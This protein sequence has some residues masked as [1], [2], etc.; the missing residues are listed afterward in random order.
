M[1]TFKSFDGVEIA[2]DDMGV[3][4][5]TLL[6]HGFA[7]D[8]RTN[9]VRPGVAGALVEA[10]RRVVLVDARGHGRSEKPHDVDAYRGGAMARDARALLDHLGIEDVA[11][12]GYSMGSFVAIRLAVSDDRVRALVLGGAGTAQIGM[13]RREH[14]DRIAD[15][16]E[17][18]DKTMIT[19][20]TALA[21][22]NFADATGA[23]RAALAA[24]QRATSEAPGMEVLGSIG[25][26]TLVVNGERDT[27][28]G[29]LGSLAEAIPGARLVVVPGDHVSAVVRPEFREAVVR[30]LT[31]VAPEARS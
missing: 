14:A 7:S 5:A 6:H 22:R 19:D 20:P 21:F 25:V 24:I 8:S 31:N 3:G 17:A 29:P 16:L 10:G 27:L 23:D 9:W 28:I 26:P 18:S 30:F 13:S 12:V 2:F 4:E 1:R 11:V 15:A